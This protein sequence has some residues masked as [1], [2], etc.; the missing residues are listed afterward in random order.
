ME[1]YD[2]IKTKIFRSSDYFLLQRKKRITEAIRFEGGTIE[3]PKKYLISILPNGKEVYFLKPGK[4]TQRK[5]A[6]INIH[7]M[8]PNIG[9]NDKS[10]TEGFSFEVIWEYLIKISIINQITFKKVLVLLYRLCF[11]IDHR[12]I[13][14]VIRYSP[15]KELLDYI[16]KIDFSLKEG[17]RDKFKKDEIGLL[18]YLNFVDLLGWNED[19]KYHVKNSKPDFQDKTKKNTG[20]VNTI[21]SIISVPLMINDFL[22]NI[23]ENVN[24]IE[25]INVR[26]ILSTMQKLSKSRGICVLSHTAL[27]S[28]LSPYLEQ[29]INKVLQREMFND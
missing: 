9:I 18:E 5:I 27:Q 13:K 20:R 14:E 21:L 26:L 16:L 29:N 25:K 1:E 19:V 11:F 22:S 7:D 23:I 10:E 4:E 24:Y 28:Y 8:F 17:F 2:V 3:K 15:S 6:N 12:E